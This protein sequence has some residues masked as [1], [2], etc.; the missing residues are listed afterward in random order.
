MPARK[1]LQRRLSGKE[2]SHPEV[3]TSSESFHYFLTELELVVAS[4]RIAWS[5]T[6]VTAA[7]RRLVKLVAALGQIGAYAK[8]G[9]SP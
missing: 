5:I 1:S 8:N 7:R 3:F 9:S 2:K 4:G 6:S